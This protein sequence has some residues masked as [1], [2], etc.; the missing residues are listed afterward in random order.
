MFGGLVMP[1]NLELANQLNNFLSGSLALSAYREA[2]MRVRV[3]KL[4]SLLLRDKNFVYEFETRYAQLKAEAL[5][6]YQFKE[7]LTYAAVSES[8]ATTSQPEVW[9]YP[10]PQ[11][12]KARVDTKA[13]AQTANYSELVCA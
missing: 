10:D 1:L 7:L 4:E 13:E 3:E 5:T 8:A 2:M 9:F 11:E 12:E 6:E